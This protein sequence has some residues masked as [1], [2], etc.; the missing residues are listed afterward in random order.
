VI[1]AV[2]TRLALLLLCIAAHPGR[3]VTPSDQVRLADG[4]FARGMYD[5]AL[6]E[7]S[8]VADQT[9]L[10]NRDVVLYR[11]AESQRALGRA[12]EADALYGQV[13]TGFPARVAAQRAALR[14]AETALAAGRFDEVV[15][16]LAGRKD[17]EV[18]AEGR[19][20]WRYFL[21]H[22]EWRG[23]Q[24]KKAEPLYRR[25]LKEDAASPYAPFARLELADVL[26]AREAAS[27]EI[28]VLLR[29]VAQA[30]PDT[31]AGRQAAQRLAGHL[32]AVREY[33]ASADAY[34]ELVRHEPGLLATVRVASAWAHF[35]AGRWNDVVALTVAS[36][37]ADSLYL[38]ANSLRQVQREAEAARVYLSLLEQHPTHAL[39]DPARYEAA[40]LAL[41]SRD[42]AAAS[43]LAAAVPRTPQR[44]ED[45]L[46]IQAEAARGA[47]DREAA[48]RWYD[49]LARDVPAGEKV[50][51]A[52]F[53]AARLAQELGRWEEASARYRA[54]AN[55]PRGRALAAD[56]L[57]ASA[58][59][60]MQVQQSGEAIADWARLQQEFPDFAKLDE[61]LYA[62]A[63]AE[64]ALD[65]PAE[66]RAQL[67]ALLKQFPRSA[68]AREA[69]YLLG[70]LLERDEKWEAAEYHY[71]L[72]TRGQADEDLVRRIE[73]R[74]VAVL[75][76]QGRHDEAAQALNALLAQTAGGQG[77]PA[78]LLDW[79]A[80]WN[81]DQR[82]WP[83]A[84]KAALALS[85]QGPAWEIPAWF[86]V[87]PCA[88]RTGV[89]G[90]RP[91]GLSQGGGGIR[92]KRSDRSCV[93]ARYPGRRRQRWRRSPRLSVP[94]RRAGRRRIHGP[95]ARAQLYGAGRCRGEGRA[96]RGS[97]AHPAERRAFVR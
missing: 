90:G 76:R 23:G 84:E 20:A 18:E 64:V 61:V 47:G 19:A 5:L 73:F 31:P 22:A 92:R 70:T 83:E 37:D 48:L 6:R 94:R 28:R 30:A 74:R 1:S 79:L 15:R 86:N 63:H 66:A 7:Y 35:K 51:A 85:R 59:A 32:Y 39:A 29:D 96:N 65:R 75:Q 60:R 89:G 38:Q 56:A 27:P 9:S 50:P 33:P 26:E 40:V 55:D 52:R 58:F 93:P 24:P 13:I 8:A 25:L 17:G 3:A 87:G 69:H 34:A 16:V 81:A 57:Y 14:R 95:S 36:S 11:M 97:P 67:E 71:R 91:R 45:L 12:A 43:R 46:W 10:T 2:K 44:A 4:L 82:R 68:Q 42:F 49:E 77:V 72:A 54:V 88:R 41:A 80:R 21:A 62:R 78:A 53:H